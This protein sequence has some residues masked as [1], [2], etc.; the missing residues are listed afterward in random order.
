MIFEGIKVLRINLMYMK[1]F[2]N[3]TFGQVFHRLLEVT[4]N[5]RSSY[6]LW[7]PPGQGW[8]N[9]QY[10]VFCSVLCSVRNF[11]LVSENTEQNI[12]VL[13]TNVLCSFIPAPGA[14]HHS[15]KTCFTAIWLRGL[16]I[17]YCFAWKTMRNPQ[18]L[19]WCC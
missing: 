19:L 3:G 18:F 2:H 6:E 11:N 17:F 14:L 5:Q 1:T 16:S 9:T 15:Q 8:K 7:Y 4:K 12:T 10:F 13:N